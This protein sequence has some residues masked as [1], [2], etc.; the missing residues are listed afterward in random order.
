LSNDGYCR[1]NSGYFEATSNPVCQACHFSC[2]ECTSNLSTS[3]LECNDNSVSHRFLSN[4]SCLCDNSYYENQSANCGSCNYSC[5]SC[6]AGNQPN[7]CS[8]CG[9]LSITKRTI[10]GD[11]TCV[12]AD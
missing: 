5:Y 9:D 1:C 6:S 7:Q 10:Q 12:C 11:G 4:G 8:N 2:K 3:C